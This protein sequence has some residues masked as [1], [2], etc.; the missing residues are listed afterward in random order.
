MLSSDWLVSN[1]N[2]RVPVGRKILRFLREIEFQ[3]YFD[4][5]REG[6]AYDKNILRKMIKLRC[7][8]IVS[9]P[10]KSYTQHF[11]KLSIFIEDQ[12]L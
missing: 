11:R 3:I 6:S 2:A 12:S 4:K 8:H 5:V 1:C 10:S 7:V 9:L